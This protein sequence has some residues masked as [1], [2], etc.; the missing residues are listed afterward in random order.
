GNT[1]IGD[2]VEATVAAL[3]AMPG[4]IYNVGGGEAV[5]VWDVV[6]KLEAITARRAE[7]IQAAARPGDQRYTSA[8]TSKIRRH[9]GWHPRVELD[10]GLARQVAWQSGEGQRQA[11]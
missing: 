3:D 8:D 5:T 7:I 2:C 9:L 6:H 1:Y 10:E 11:A 4:E